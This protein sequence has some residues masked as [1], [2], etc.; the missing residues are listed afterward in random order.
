MI[1]THANPDGTKRYAGRFASFGEAGFY[2]DAQGLAISSLGLG[3][4]L[5]AVSAE[6]D[7]AYTAAATL[8]LDSGINFLDTSLN[9][10]HQ[11]SERAIGKALAGRDRG[12][13][14]ICT[15]AGFLV[16]DATPRS[17]PPGEVVGRMHCMT[18]DFLEDQL[19]RSLRNLGV[20][21]IDVFYLHNP[22]TQLRF[23]SQ[24]VFYQRCR[25]AFKK[26]ERLADEGQIQYYG[27]ATWD[28]YRQNG[29]AGSLSLTKLAKIAEDTGGRNHRFR[30][31][32]LPFNMA[33]P[34]AYLQCA[35]S[36]NGEP[37]EERI[38]VLQA[39]SELG[40]TV[41][42]SATLLQTRL[43]DGQSEALAESLGLPD[44]ACRAIQ[45]TRSAP[46][47]SVALVGMG[48]SQH[49]RENLRVA[50]H[51]A[52]APGQFAQLFGG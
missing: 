42:A 52:L 28:G 13:L 6:A 44:A 14:V 26:L 18:P 5:G 3:S 12:E 7:E 27:T 38:S 35:E 11:H 45:Y 9:Y 47:V 33:M 43:L 4:Y 17:L 34:E 2:R 51:R 40:I 39:A 10:R 32:Q 24:D 20:D 36:R 30:F 50:G 15:K 46:G 41:I 31:V 37:N 48:N 1:H 29:G 8:A 49:V 22:E 25:I 23:A 16:P 21:T 19:H